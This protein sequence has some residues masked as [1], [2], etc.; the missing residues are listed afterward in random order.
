MNEAAQFFADLAS[1]K[2]LSSLEHWQRV[3]LCS[4]MEKARLCQSPLSGKGYNK[5]SLAWWKNTKDRRDPAAW[6]AIR[7]VHPYAFKFINELVDTGR[8]GAHDVREFYEKMPLF[9]WVVNERTV[10]YYDVT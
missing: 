4:D 2:D 3:K 10:S 8:V 1:V 7:S 6:V 9:E 5:K